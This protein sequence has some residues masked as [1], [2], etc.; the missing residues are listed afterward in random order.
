[1][2]PP[3]Q[4][5]PRSTPQNSGGTPAR[6]MKTADDGEELDFFPWLAN[7]WEG[8]VLLL[9]SLFL[10]LSI[11]LFYAWWTPPVYQA[12]AMLQIQA[13]KERPSDPSLSKMESL[14]SEP[15]FAHS[16]IEIIKSNLVLSRTI[17]TLGLDIVAEPALKPIVGAPL[18]RGNPRA[19][20]MEVDSLDLPVHMRGLVF[21]VTALPE[22]GFRWDDPDGGSLAKGKLKEPLVATYQGEPVKLQVR[23]LSAPPGQTFTLTLRPL[24]DA[25]DGL[26]QDLDVSERGKLTN[27]LGLT[28]RGPNALKCM[29]ILNQIVDQY[30]HHKQERRS[31]EITKAQS[32]L[33]G[34]MPELKAQLETAES[35]LNS[36]RSRSGSVDLSREADAYI[37]QSSS[38]GSQ[39][40]AL[41]Q[42]KEELLRTYKESADVVGTLDQQISKLQQELNQV[43]SKV[44]VLP[45]LQQEVVRLSRDV[46]VATELYT[47]LLNNLQQLQITGASDL[48]SVAV[49]DRA[50]VNP[51]PIAPKKSVIVLFFLFLGLGC[52]IGLV[53]LR[54]ALRRGIEDH[55]IIESKLGLPVFVTIPHSKAQR[56]HDETMQGS[57]DGMH[58]LASQEPGDLAVESLRSLRTMLN[59][60]MKDAANP[61]I[62]MSGPA[63]MIGKSFISANFAA[64]LAQAGSTVL[65]VDGDLRRGKLHKYFGVKN[66]LNGLSDVLSGQQKWE[67][68]LQSTDIEG[69]GLISTGLLPPNPSDLLMT[70]RLSA[71]LDQ[72][73]KKY[74]Y[75]VIDAPPVLPVTDATIIGSV[76]GTVLL[77]AKFGQH[78]IDEMRTAQKRFES[79]GIQVKGC[80]FNDIRPVGWGNNYRRYN[81]IYSYGI[82]K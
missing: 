5:D 40:S 7:L 74:D 71:F 44:R 47:A 42:K 57:G 82:K 28:L 31:G 39:I 72:A 48:G 11:G 26:R 6:R 35:R 32:V 25:I 14:F 45:S 2:N 53:A 77:V 70:P 50:T 3:F 43:D 60:Y 78:P 18:A 73:S 21:H 64:V 41:K 63:P 76:A 80:V 13:K 79:H 15:A 16:E 58:L 54:K 75:I 20:A 69:L 62:L 61:V 49:V 36:F 51:D 24:Q 8:R 68:V 81:Y 55:R 27:I 9:A 38:L 19:P 33:L 17:E 10:F 56:V 12:E 29:T 34:K 67:A 52:G 66:R 22:G 65:L 1:M 37:L 46:Q 59:F 4:P 30:V 23:R